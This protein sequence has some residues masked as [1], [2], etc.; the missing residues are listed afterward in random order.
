MRPAM[1]LLYLF[2]GR[3]RR[4]DEQELAASL[5]MAVTPIDISR[6]PSHDLADLHIWEDV[7]ASATTGYFDLVMMSFPC[8][9]F[10][11]SRDARGGPPP[12]RGPYGK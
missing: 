10:S 3:V 5:G 7:I 6:C 2:S 1:R 9:S 12:L 11:V 4:Y 8:S